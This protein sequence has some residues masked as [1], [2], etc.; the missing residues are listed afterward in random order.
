VETAEKFSAELRAA[1]GRFSAAADSI[2]AEVRS[3]VDGLRHDVRDMAQR[4]DKLLIG[5][6]KRDE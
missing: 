1:E 6:L 4:L 2:R 5:I 3:A